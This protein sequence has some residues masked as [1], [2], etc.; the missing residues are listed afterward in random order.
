MTPNE[1]V[2]H[3]QKKLQAHNP[4][5]T[6]GCPKGTAVSIASLAGCQCDD[7]KAFNALLDERKR[8]MATYSA[9]GRSQLAG[10]HLVIK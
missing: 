1:A 10:S 8:A 3:L 5:D 2:K 4:V 6:S 7:C 9:F